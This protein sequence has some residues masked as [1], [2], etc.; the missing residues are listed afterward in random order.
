M[1]VRFRYAVFRR[2]DYST[3]FSKLECVHALKGLALPRASHSS[4]I[5]LVGSRRPRSTLAAA[6]VLFAHA[7]VAVAEVDMIISP[8]K[9]FQHGMVLPSLHTRT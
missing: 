4:E 2:D 7:A 6:P 1:A 3:N 5:A 8:N 9:W